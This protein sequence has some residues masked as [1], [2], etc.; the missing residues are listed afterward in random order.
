MTAL[1][2]GIR[3]LLNSK[4]FTLLFLFNL[5][6]GIC[7]FVALHS[8]R[9][10]VNRILDERAKELL[11]SDLAI[12]ARR[13]LSLEE[14]KNL[15][16]VLNEKV[17]SVSVARSVYS[18]AKSFSGKGR[19]RLAQLKAVEQSYPYYGRVLLGSGKNYSSSMENM[20][21]Q[22]LAWLDPA[23]MRQLE[24][25]IGDTIKLGDLELKVADTVVEDSTSSWGGFGLAPKIYISVESLSK[26]NLVSFGSLV[27]HSLLIKLKDQWTS[28]KELA[29]LKGEIEKLVT[30]PAISIKAPDSASEQVGRVLNYLSDYLG[31]VGLVALFLSGI[32]AGYLFQNYLFEKLQD[33]G[34]LKS[35]GMGLGG[36]FSIYIFQL[37]LL[38]LTAVILANALAWIALPSISSYFY[39]WI[40]IKGEMTL[41]WETF[42]L[43]LLV[44][45]GASILICAP[46]LFKMVGKRVKNLFEGG[47]FFRWEFQ[48]RD[49]LLYLPLILFMWGLAIVQAHS[50]MIG[51]IFTLAL[52][53]VTLLVALVFPKLLGKLDRAYLQKTSLDRPGSLTS[54]LALRYFARDRLSSTL[55][56]SAITIGTMLLSLIG[57]LETSLRGEL[58]DNPQG[59]PS[60]FLFDIQEEQKEPLMKLMGENSLPVTSMA[61]MVRSRILKINGKEHKRSLEEEGFS[62]REEEASRRFRNRGVNLSY[63]AAPNS[64]EEIIEGK[65]FSGDYQE[66]GEAL[67]ELSLERRYAKRLGVG[68][69]DTIT[70]DILGIELTGRVVNLRKVKWTSFLPNFFIVFQPGVLEDAPKTFL[71][72][73]GDMEAEKS[74]DAQDLVVEDFPNVSMVNVSELID[75]M[76][77]I[78]QAM[79]LALGAMSLLCMS[80]GFF[81]LFAIIQNQLKKKSFEVA[82]QKVFGLEAKKLLMSLLKEYFL[83]VGISCVFGLGFSLALGQIVSVLFFDGVWR[84]DWMFMLQVIGVVFSITG[85]LALGA[86][87]TFYSLKVKT[88]LR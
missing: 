28:S 45:L 61:P 33:I 55:S 53:I 84:L 8:F 32:G 88:L 24:V 2:I 48:N 6:L 42:W 81:V 29:S 80:V 60:L 39:E 7:G 64:A 35:V 51:S 25:S 18:M 52:L 63:A 12:S 56:I 41:S 59:K 78:F 79:A 22:A 20:Q 43:S 14:R 44:S 87:R 37:S 13:E 30:D 58:L 17:E 66:G 16:S 49:F 1:K 23:L 27:T 67:P 82:I 74:L 46:I 21:T 40:N 15:D 50:F 85:I 26:T 77:S 10:N 19:S 36:I 86:G 5:L 57:Q 9:D 47:Q 54:G 11:S 72:A 4:G 3:D 71:A 68:I 76:M 83:L 62:T 31:L 73:L 75:K 34:I 38:S 69:G 65:P 70:F